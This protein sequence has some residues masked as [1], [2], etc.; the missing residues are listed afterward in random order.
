MSREMSQRTICN[1]MKPYLQ[2]GILNNYYFSNPQ[3]NPGNPLSLTLNCSAAT[4]E[5]IMGYIGSRSDGQG[6]MDHMAISVG[7]SFGSTRARI[8][9]NLLEYGATLALTKQKTG[10]TPLSMD[11]LLEDIMQALDNLNLTPKNM[12][13]RA[14]YTSEDSVELFLDDGKRIFTGADRV[15]LLLTKE[16]NELT[17]SATDSKVIDL[18]KIIRAYALNLKHDS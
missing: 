11:V 6:L 4:R 18:D 8:R 14:D 5:E 7:N 1:K 9:A 10:K 17:I 12:G 16:F 2:R 13:V 15:F 3:L